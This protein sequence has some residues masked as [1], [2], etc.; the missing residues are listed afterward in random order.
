MIEGFERT[1]AGL[2]K[3]I[4]YDL[5]KTHLKQLVDLG[6][7]RLV[8][9]VI[10]RLDKIKEKQLL[11]QNLTMMSIDEYIEQQNNECWDKI[12]H[13]KIFQ[14]VFAKANYWHTTTMTQERTRFIDDASQKF[15]DCFIDLTA[16]FVRRTHPIE[17]VIFQKHA[18]SKLQLNAHPTDNNTREALS[19]EFEKM[20]DRTS[21]ILAE[22]FYYK[23]IC[24]M[25][26]ILNEI[27]PEMKDLYRTSLTLEKCIN[28]THALILR[29]A[30]SV[31]MATLRYSYLDYNVKQD[32][33]SELIHIVPAVAFNIAKNADQDGGVVFSEKKYLKQR[34]Y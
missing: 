8:R 18:Y 14:P 27:C 5:P 32:A 21:D 2:N 31:I 29:V 1:K 10:E 34:N 12:Y 11:P 20:V 28:Q 26:N 4:E 13:E 19:I 17:Q 16:E 3:F 7:K 22:H 9:Y 6:R 25:E 33:I 15:H 24:E 30:R 23:Y